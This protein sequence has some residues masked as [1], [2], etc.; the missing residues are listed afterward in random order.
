M[1]CFARFL[2]ARALQQENPDYVFPFAQVRRD[3]TTRE[4][5]LDEGTVAFLRRQLD[6]A[7]MYGIGEISLRHRPFAFSP[8]EGDNYPADGPVALQIYDLAASEG[9]PVIIHLEHE[10]SD[11]L[12][13]ALEH[14]RSTIII[15][16]HMGDAQLRVSY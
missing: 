7:V 11:E 14:N 9:I 10:F 12:A 4:L 1:C 8:P 6:N 5:L 16:A 2:D 3:R 15:W 13:R